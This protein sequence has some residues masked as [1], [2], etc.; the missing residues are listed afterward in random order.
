MTPV[1]G[2]SYDDE[3]ALLPGEG[4]FLANL[5][6]PG[7]LHAVFVRSPLAHAPIQGL[8]LEQARRTPGVV[9]VITGEDLDTRPIWSTCSGCLLC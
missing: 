4:P 7:L 2:L 1:I 3:K 5:S 8:D 6:Q 9:A